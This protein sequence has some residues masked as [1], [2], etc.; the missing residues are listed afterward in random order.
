VGER[1]GSRT[2]RDEAA[3]GEL[4]GQALAQCRRIA[5]CAHGRIVGRSRE[6][7]GRFV[8]LGARV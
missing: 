5:G 4:E 7:Q 1:V 6:F 8:S 2:R 3:P